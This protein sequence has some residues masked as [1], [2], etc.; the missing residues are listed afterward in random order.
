DSSGAAI[1][2]ASVKLISEQTANAAGVQTNGLFG[3]YTAAAD[4]RRLQSALRLAFGDQ[5]DIRELPIDLAPHGRGELCS[6]LC[7]LARLGGIVA[8]SIDVRHLCSHRPE[9]HG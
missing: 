2:G 4:G 7:R 1:A 3:Q 6:A 9:V 5:D 8:F